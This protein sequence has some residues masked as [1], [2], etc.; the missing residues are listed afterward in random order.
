LSDASDEPRS[1]AGHVALD[2]VNT[3]VYAGD[4]LEAD[5]LRD[6]ATFASWCEAQGALGA[7]AAGER[8]ARLPES[9]EL[10]LAREL[11][12][13]LRLVTTA[14]AR[15]EPVPAEPLTVFS[16]AYARALADAEPRI[17]PDGLEWRWSPDDRVHRLAAAA[18][19]LLHHRRLERIKECP[20][21]RFVFYDATKNGSR[22]W[23]DMADCGTEDKMR[24]YVE[25]R[26]RRRV[27]DGAP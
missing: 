4:D 13:A 19:E 2:F 5:V 10:A 27:D 9:G 8:R 18:S 23:C 20:G 22:R 1:V 7:N 17:G 15:R 6:V 25:K 11:R 24:R 3:S 16:E 14:L 12:G 26:A 21:C